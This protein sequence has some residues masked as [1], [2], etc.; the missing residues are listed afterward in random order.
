M[1]VGSN[2][3][4]APHISSSD[5]LLRTPQ[6]TLLVPPKLLFCLLQLQESS[7]RPIDFSPKPFL[8]F[9]F[10]SL[11]PFEASEDVMKRFRLLDVLLVC[12]LMIEIMGSVYYI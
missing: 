1:K 6:E 5:F 10:E 11:N 2:M 7:L 9:F 3:R 4:L 12:W 8:V